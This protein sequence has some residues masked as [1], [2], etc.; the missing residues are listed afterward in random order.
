MNW[1]HRG[2]ARYVEYGTSFGASRAF[3]IQRSLTDTIYNMNLEHLSADVRDGVRGARRRRRAHRRHDV[4]DVPRPPPA[5]AGGRD[6]ARPAGHDGVPPRGL[7]PARVLLR[8]PLR[9]A[10]DRLPLAAR[11]ARAC[12]TSTPAASAPTWSSTT[13]STSCCSRCPTTTRT[14]TRTGPFAQVASIA[15][16]DR[17]IERVMHAAG[18][19]DAFLE[20]HAVIVCSDHSQ[21]QV[22]DEI[23]LFRA[24]DGFDVL[25]PGGAGASSAGRRSR[26]ARPRARRRST[27]ST[28]SARAELMP[29]VERTA[30]APRG[31]RPRDAHDRPPRRR[32]GDPRRARRHRASC[33]SPRAASSRTCAASAGASRATSACSASRSATACSTPRDYP[34]ALGRVWSALRCRD[35]RRGA[36]LGRARLR[37]RRLGRRAATS[38]AARTARCTPTTRTARCCGAATGPERAGRRATSGRCATS[39]ADGRSSTSGVPRPAAR[40]ARPVS[41]AAAVSAARA[42]APARSRP[43]GR[44]AEQRIST[45]LSH[46][47]SSAAS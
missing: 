36:A 12:A 35:R 44:A 26:C 31:R 1:Y 47:S 21:S 13:C 9:L 33:A 20:D 23:D 39:S 10:P 40:G 30:L 42:A 17:Q 14:R 41:A 24:F 43:R 4:P 5:R 46:G 2:E 27:C 8:R 37:V 22:E 15:A 18:G 29:R 34:D 7:R 19:P 38:A 32:G 3:G 45:A 16:A 25:P 28:A 11:A 6:R